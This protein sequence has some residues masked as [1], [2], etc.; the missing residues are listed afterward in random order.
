MIGYPVDE[1]SYTW[2]AEHFTVQSYIYPSFMCKVS[3]LAH[4][5]FESG[6]EDYAFWTEQ[7]Q[8]LS[9]FILSSLTLSKHENWRHLLNSLMSCHLQSLQS[10]MLGQYHF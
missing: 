1:F 8:T 7:L 9:M 4:F 5:P 3:T 2:I 6:C 10:P